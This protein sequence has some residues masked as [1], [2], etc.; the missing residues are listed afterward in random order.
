MGW[1]KST[2]STGKISAD[3][4]PEAPNRHDRQH[5][6]EAR[7]AFFACLDR[8]NILDGI[9]DDTSAQKQCGAES[10][11]FDRNCAQTWVAFSLSLSLY[12]HPSSWKVKWIYELL[13]MVPV[14]GHGLSGGV[15][16]E[17]KSHGI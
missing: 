11:V 1:F 4:K 7:D 15:F 2:P 8:N 10:V 6:W 14:V 9:K 12:E 17:E 13:L 3:G 5:C 16:Q